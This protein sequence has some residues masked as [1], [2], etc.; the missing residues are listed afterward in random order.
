MTTPLAVPT[1]D[2]SDFKASACVDW[3][4]VTI[5]TVHETQFRFIKAEV[6]RI[7]GGNS[8]AYP[9]NK[10]PDTGQNATVFTLTF[11]D[12]LANDLSALTDTLRELGLKFPFKAAPTISAIE[13]ACDFRHKGQAT[14]REA[15]TLAMTY[16]LQSSLFAPDATN[17]RQFVPTTKANRFMVEGTRLDPTLNYRI[18]NQGDD[19]S[20]Q[21]YFKRTNAGK[22]LE[23]SEWRAR[24]EVTLQGK[25]LDGLAIKDLSDLDGFDFRK[26]TPFFR[27]RRPID[28]EQLEKNM[29]GSLVRLGALRR[30]RPLHDATPE[31]GMDSFKDVGR[32]GKRNCRL[33]ESRHLEPVSEL[34]EAVK[35]SMRRLKL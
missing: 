30:N 22:S 26:L 6:D 9:R 25:A 7:S 13:V 19:V 20:W 21:V 32:I 10:Q 12:D 33:A 3:L 4:Q 27:F 15:A 28:M 24:V 34:Q 35:G 8:F 17:A 5:C 18:G 29:G 14:E 16:R 2:R 31:R 23:P 1:A 11:H